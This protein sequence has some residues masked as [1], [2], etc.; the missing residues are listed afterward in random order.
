MGKRMSARLSRRAGGSIA[1]GGFEVVFAGAGALA[2]PLPLTTG[3][4]NPGRMSAG[5]EASV[6]GVAAAGAGNSAGFLAAAGCSSSESN[7]SSAGSEAGDDSGSTSNRSAASVL[8]LRAAGATALFCTGK[9]AAFG[10][11]G[12]AASRASSA[13]AAGTGCDGQLCTVGAASIGG[14]GF[15]VSPLFF[16]RPRAT[17]SVPFA[18]STLIGLVRTRFAPIRNALAT[19]D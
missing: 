17:L 15:R 5:R 4:A 7:R 19:P 2:A 11:C 9:G 14:V 16:S 6:G 8:R 12:G 13:P 3:F 18:C 10:G 1:A